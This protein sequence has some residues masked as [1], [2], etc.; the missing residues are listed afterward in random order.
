MKYFSL[1]GLL[2]ELRLCLIKNNIIILISLSSPYQNSSLLE[3]TSSIIFNLNSIFDPC[4]YTNINL[5][6]DDVNPTI[7]TIIILRITIPI[8]RISTGNPS[9]HTH[10]F[11][12]KPNSTSFDR[13]SMQKMKFNKRFDVTLSFDYISNIIHSQIILKIGDCSLLL[14]LIPISFSSLT[15]SFFGFNVLIVSLCKHHEGF[16]HLSTDIVP[17]DFQQLICYLT[18]K[19]TIIL[20]ILGCYNLFEPCSSLGVC[21]FSSLSQ[22]YGIILFQL[23]RYFYQ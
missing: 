17:F 14:I 15:S 3:C 13:F 5:Q 22:N 19:L 20:L 9:C 18:D 2:I 8:P 12:F 21:Y 1:E 23:L 6:D 11:S 16:N 7:I 4:T 10:G